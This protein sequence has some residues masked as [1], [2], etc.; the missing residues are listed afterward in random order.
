MMNQQPAFIT[1]AGIEWD[2]KLNRNVTKLDFRSA[3]ISH[4]NLLYSLWPNALFSLRSQYYS[5][6]RKGAFAEESKLLEL[7]E[8]FYDISRESYHRADR[9]ALRFE[10]DDAARR[11]VF[12][13]VDGWT[14]PG[15]VGHHAVND[16]LVLFKRAKGR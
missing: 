4:L 9:V 15:D 1:L 2:L 3:T 12:Q 6:G 13:R 14:A 11:V 5:S 7:N 8:A 16:A 10:G